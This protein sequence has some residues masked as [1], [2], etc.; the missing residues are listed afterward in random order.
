MGSW[1][2]RVSGGSGLEAMAVRAPTPAELTETL[3]LQFLGR[4][5]SREETRAFLAMLEPGFENRILPFEQRTHVPPRAPLRRVSWSNH[6]HP[7]A[8]T[9]KL[10]AEKTSREGEPPTNQ[11]RTDWRERFEDAVWG[12]VNSPEF[13]WAP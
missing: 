7:D 9:V 13:V 12:L 1:T 11:L 10:E 6:L 2:T 8:T 3:F 4:P 5:P